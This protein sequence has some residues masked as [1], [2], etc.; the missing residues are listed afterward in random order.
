MTADSEAICRVFAQGVLD[1][2]AAHQD[3]DLSP[4]QRARL[5]S[6]IGED[7]RKIGDMIF[8]EARPVL[9]SAAAGELAPAGVDLSRCH[10]HSQLQF[11]RN[12]L[13]FHYEHMN[14]V[15][16]IVA[17]LIGA[18]SRDEVVQ[19]LHSGLRVAWITKAE[20]KRLSALGYRHR[21]PDP[22]A[23]YREAGIVLLA[24]EQQ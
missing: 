20:N 21:R 2:A 24:Q 15:A 18:D 3:L 14:P 17:A 12:R 9:V 13:L 10:W 22:E 16:H 6:S 8:P 1:K 23:A 5:K 4:Y 11:D 7:V 19:V